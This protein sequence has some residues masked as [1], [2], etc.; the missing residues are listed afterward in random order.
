MTQMSS[1]NV[2]P[3][4]LADPEFIEFDTWMLAPDEMP[5]DRKTGLFIPYY[6]MQTAAFTFFGWGT[7]NLRRRV[8]RHYFV[9]TDDPECLHHNDKANGLLEN[10]EVNWEKEWLFNSEMVCMDCRGVDWGSKYRRDKG[11]DHIFSLA[12]I[13]RMAHVLQR[14]LDISTPE[15]K[16]ILRIVKGIAQGWDLI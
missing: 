14:N 7:E 9:L 5:R 10:G 6:T 11:A 2:E 8:K 15:L 12:S 16:R 13:E 3:M 1:R 4:I